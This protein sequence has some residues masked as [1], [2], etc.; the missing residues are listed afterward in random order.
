[1]L[2]PLNDRLVFIGGAI[3]PILQTESPF[4]SARVTTDVDG[5]AATG[6]ARDHAALQGELRARG[7]REATTER[8]AH[9]WICP[10]ADQSRFDL[11]PAG[12]HLG[13]SGQVWDQVAIDTAVSLEIEPGLTIRHSSA[14]T[15]LAL[16][17]AAFNDRGKTDPFASHDLEDIVGLIASRPTIVDDARSAPGT[18]LA[19]VRD[20]SVWL[21]DHRDCDELLAA[22]LTQSFDAASAIAT[23]R[24]RIGELAAYR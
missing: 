6:S 1:M 20:W 18:V 24:E 19:F 23:T 22:N 15:F 8:H 17:W 2:G 10:D 13:S 3:A 14:A 11:V 16:K 5:V 7:F 9:R 4:L 12:D 21:R